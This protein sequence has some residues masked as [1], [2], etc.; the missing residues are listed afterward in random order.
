LTLVIYMGLSQV[1]HIQA[2]LLLGLPA[3][4]PVALLQDISLP[5]QRQALTQLGDL[6][7]CVSEHGFVSPTVMVVGHVVAGMHALGLSED[8]TPPALKN[9]P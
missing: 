2:Q 1:S 8:A 5:Q 3:Q 7:Q 4:T 9:L 6:A